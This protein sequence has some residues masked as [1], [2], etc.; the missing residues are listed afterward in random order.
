MTPPTRTTVAHD[1]EADTTIIPPSAI[2][3]T[4]DERVSPGKSC[5][6]R[7]DTPTP[8]DDSRRRG[9]RSPRAPL[10]FLFT[11]VP[12][13][14]VDDRRVAA[15]A[16]DAWILGWKYAKGNG[17]FEAT[18]R[19][20]AEE[21]GRDRQ[22]IATWFKKLHNLGWATITPQDGGANLV[23]LH[24]DLAAH[25]GFRDLVGEDRE[26]Y[27]RT[28]HDTAEHRKGVEEHREQPPA[29]SPEPVDEAP[30]DAEGCMETDRGVYG[31]RYGLSPAQEHG[32]ITRAHARTRETRTHETEHCKAR[33]SSSDQVVPERLAR[34]VRADAGARLRKPTRRPTPQRPTLPADLANLYRVMRAE[35]VNVRWHDLDEGEH[36]TLRG[37]LAAL[38]AQQLARIA[39]NTTRAALA[40][41]K[42]PAFHVRAYLGTWAQHAPVFETGDEHQDH[43]VADLPMFSPNCLQH[44]TRSL[45]CWECSTAAS[46]YLDAETSHAPQGAAEGPEDALTGLDALRAG[47]EALRARQEPA[48]DPAIQRARDEKRA[49]REAA[50]AELAARRQSHHAPTDAEALIGNPAA[51]LDPRRSWLDATGTA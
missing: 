36:H 50:R 45:P 19:E 38:G 41:G 42:R 25:R 33:G 1:G 29:V 5:D 20:V 40:D 28:D 32:S 43:A 11:P 24:P 10:N 16:R 23:V 13:A 6:Y 44:P 7:N 51:D 46:E 35:G 47:R 4:E 31:N 8:A 34:G 37:L 22:W 14:L 3:S 18:W 12:D 39:A 17:A 15:Q 27:T 49:G 21:F 26:F 30:M 2:I 9:R 48:E